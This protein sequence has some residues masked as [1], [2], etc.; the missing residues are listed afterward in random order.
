M[1]RDASIPSEAAPG[2][3]PGQSNERLRDLLIAVKEIHHAL[4]VAENEA[5]LFQQICNSLKQVSYVKFAWIGLAEKGTFD[6]KPVAFAGFED[7]YLSSIKVTWDDSEYGKGPTGMA[8]KTGQPSVIRDTST[9]PKYD[10]WRKEA[11]KRGYASS[12]ALPLIHEGEV[13][14][15]LNVYSERKDAFGDQEV[16]F[17]SAV[18]ED[19]ALGVRSL[20]LQR[21]LHESEAKY[22]ILVEQSL[23]GIV[24]AQGPPPR[25]VFAN[26]AMAKILGYT[27]DELTSL[28]L[29]ETEG[30]VHPEDRAVFFGRFSDRLQGKPVP[31]RYEVRGIR[32]DGETRWLEISSNRIEY[33]GQP[34]VQ[35]TFTD[36]TERKLAEQKL[37]LQSE[38]TENMFEGV[39][40]ARVNDGVIVYANRRFEQI[41]GYDSGELIGKNITIVNAP[42]EGKSPE[43]TAHEIEASLEESG[44]WVGEIRNVKKDGTLFWCQANVSALESS[45]YGKIL[46]SV[47]EDITESKKMEEELRRLSQFRESVIDNAHVWID[48]LDEK[49]NV[50]VWNKAAEAISDYSREEV[51]GHDKIWEWL[52][53][54][55]KYRTYLTGLVADVVQHGRVEEDFETT[56]R[57]KDGQIRTISWNERSLVDELG[58]AIGSIAL[59]RDVTEHKKMEEEL[60]RYSTQLEQLITE[61]T[62]E[63]AASKDF[64]E[65]LIQTANAIVVGLDNHGNVRILNQAAERITGYTSRELEGRNW[66]EVIVPKDRYPEVWKEFERLTAG[67]LPKNFENPILTK[68]G[69]ERY[70]VWQNNEVREQGQPVGTISFGIDITERKRMEEAVRESEK[71]FRTLVEDSAVAMAVFSGLQG[72]VHLVNRKF[73]ELLGYTLEDVPDLA[74]WW[75]LAYP[76]QKYRDQVKAEWNRKVEKAVKTRNEI[77]PIEL[78]VTCKDSSIRQVELHSSWVGDRIVSTLVDLTEH[79]QMEEDLRSARGQ[80]EH[81][82]TSNPA[83]IYAGKPNADYSDFDAIYMSTSVVSLLGFEPHEFIGHSELWY[84]RVHP[85]DLPRY[86]AEMPVLWKEGQHTFEYRFLHKDEAYRWIREEVKVIRDAAGKPFEVMGYWTDITERKRAER[87][88][89]ESERLAAI[90]QTSAMVGHDL[91]NPLQGIAGV[92]YLAKRNLESRKTTDRKAVTE[93]LDTIQEQITYMD[94]IVSDLQDYA[95]PLVPKLTETDL[96]NLIRQTLSAIKVPAAVKVSVEVEKAAQNVMIDPT[97]MR[98]TFTNLAINAIQ[99]MPKRGK[100]TI[101]A[102]SKRDSTI[103]TVEDTGAG[104]PRKNLAKLFSP[105]F[106]TKAKGQGLGLAVCKRLVEVQGGTIT[107]KSKPR[108]GTVFTIK[109]PRGKREVAS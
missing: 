87:R 17:L 79:K 67:G 46:V 74:H 11:L 34:A 80:L 33:N 108:K 62:R 26:L 69:E 65:N 31:P 91:R 9:D 100:L 25:L 43:D 89:A 5:E 40:L 86:L 42:V 66:F 55:E 71:R 70:V 95:Q 32:K 52:Y 57:R 29:K 18:A 99:A 106:A 54:D 8:I 88:L 30:L 104:I 45:E 39:V 60:R 103:M 27:P 35:A 101:R 96:P 23:Q 50:V 36:I 83:V 56:I 63:L 85:D 22:R 2:Q 37:R 58:K 16:Q 73:T 6:I 102:R 7:G 109:M 59:G 4:L 76:D 19:V 81:L 82:I 53:P 13:I 28:S 21:N 51:I 84:S 68:S 64:A 10:A 98:R 20:R 93:L 14:G 38:I 3:L 107:V 44:G 61:R 49:A 75:P 48:V 1:K 105:F 24:I 90:G 78:A 47:Q 97:L 92:V 12:I 94:K 15:A 72:D 77:E 41:F